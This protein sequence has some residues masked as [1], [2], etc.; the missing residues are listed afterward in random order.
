MFDDSEIC[1]LGNSD[2]HISDSDTSD[3][4]IS[5]SDTSDSDIS[6][7]GVREPA[8][9]DLQRSDADVSDSVIIS[10]SETSDSDISD[11]DQPVKR[12]SEIR[13]LAISDSAFNDSDIRN[14]EI[15]DSATRTSAT[16]LSDQREIRTV[17]NDSEI[18]LKISDSETNGL[19]VTPKSATRNQRLGRPRLRHHRLGRRT[20]LD[21]HEPLEYQRLGHSN[22]SDSD[23]LEITGSDSAI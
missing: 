13:H 11:S 10:V 16:Q 9:T 22:I 5:G 1:H 18:R 15:S 12:D 4:N 2:S 17:Q 20:T 6:D 3:S 21:I 14:L 7:S 23:G 8:F 19:C